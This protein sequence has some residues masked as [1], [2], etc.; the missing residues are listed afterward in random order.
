ME[1]NL[2]ESSYMEN[3][4]RNSQKK[5]KKNSRSKILLLELKGILGFLD[6]NDEL[7]LDEIFEKILFTLQVTKIKF[8]QNFIVKI[9][10]SKIDNTNFHYLVF[11]VLKESYSISF[12]RLE[13]YFKFPNYFLNILNIEN[14][15]Q[16]ENNKIQNKVELVTSKI[17]KISLFYKEINNPN[18]DN[19]IYFSLIENA[20]NGNITFKNLLKNIILN[21]PNLISTF[22]KYKK[23]I[24]KILCPKKIEMDGFGIEHM[25]IPEFL[26]TWLKKNFYQ[27]SFYKNILIIYGKAYLGKTFFFRNFLTATKFNGKNP[28]HAYFSSYFDAK[29]IK[30]ENIYIIIEN[31]FDKNIINKIIAKIKN[32][33][34]IIILNK[35]DFFLEIINEIKGSFYFLEDEEYLCPPEYIS[36]FQNFE[37]KN[38][39]TNIDILIENSS[40]KK[41]ELLMSLFN[42]NKEY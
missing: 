10:V 17:K 18:K 5:Y 34:I 41:R 19:S 36:N 27:N 21:Y 2:I 20:Q 35:K 30:E 29:E 3:E 39:K 23:E 8:Q 4:S 14:F 13:E 31:I 26:K 33:N 28:S 6:I 32:K 24:K 42:I 37:K 9:L 40:F 25:W 16:I 7:T 15:L 1:G 12:K 22:L 38:M 11:L